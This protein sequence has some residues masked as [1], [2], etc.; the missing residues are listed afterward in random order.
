MEQPSS[1][2]SATLSCLP[3]QVLGAQLIG[4]VPFNTKCNRAKYFVEQQRV[5]VLETK[6]L[7][8]PTIGNH[9]QHLRIDIAQWVT[10]PGDL[11]L[12]LHDD[13]LITDRM[14]TAKVKCLLCL[15]R[16]FSVRLRIV[17]R[18]TP[19]NDFCL[20]CNILINPFT[21]RQE[22]AFDKDGT[23]RRRC[24]RCIEWQKNVE[25]K[26]NREEQLGLVRYGTTD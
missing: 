15:R 5:E 11:A 7:I 9:D 13:N 26:R 24:G 20:D 6:L 23:C 22:L 12:H 2:P 19:N 18:F 25:R 16:K 14:Q 17:K 21:D 8:G 4:P 10:P 3:A 1:I